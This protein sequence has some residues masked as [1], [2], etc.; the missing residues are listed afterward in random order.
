MGFT[1]NVYHK[2]KLHS[3]AW[4]RLIEV[5]NRSLYEWLELNGEIFPLKAS[6]HLRFLTTQLNLSPFNGNQIIGII[7]HFMT[8][9]IASGI[10]VRY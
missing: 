8:F 6:F 7:L 1:N 2:V 9:Q 10:I 4:L 3:S 5:S